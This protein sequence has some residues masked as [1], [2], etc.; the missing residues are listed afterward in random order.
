MTH[1]RADVGIGPYKEDYSGLPSHREL[2]SHYGSAVS[3]PAGSALSQKMVT[4]VRPPGV[5]V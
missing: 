5:Q 1:R 2:V 4:L 3:S